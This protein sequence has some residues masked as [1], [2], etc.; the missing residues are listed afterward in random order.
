MSRIKSIGISKRV[1][2]V[3]FSL[4]VLFAGA[5]S[6]SDAPVLC[7]EADTPVIESGKP[8]KV[9]VR[10]MVRPPKVRDRGRVPL[11]VAIVLDKSGS[12][13]SDSKMENARL[14]ALEALERLDARDIASVVAY[15]S[16]ARVLVS[17]RPAGDLSGFRRAIMGVRAGGSTALFGGVELGA[18]K[19]RSLVSEGYIPRLIILS[20]GQAN[21][22]PS[23]TG[24]L[25]ALGR[26][27]SRD[28]MTITTIGLGLD[29][30]EDLMT[31]LA[32]E[33]GGNAYFAK[34]ASAL[35]GIFA[36]DMD[37]AVALTARRVR[38]TIECASSA[39]P[40]RVVGRSG[41]KSGN[42]LTASIDNL[43]GADKYALFEIEV[44]D[45]SDVSETAAATVKLEYIDAG[46]G[47]T[48]V[49]RSPLNLA[50][51]RDA[52]EAENSRNHE[53][54]AQTEL[55]RNA[56][57]REEVI[58]L[59]DEGRA[60]EAAKMLKDRKS[61]LNSLPAS[62]VMAAPS[63]SAEAEYFDELADDIEA[64]GRMSPEQRKR[65]KNEAYMEKNQQSKAD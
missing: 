48:V 60:R 14:G 37:D 11:A 34:D 33:S 29:Y 22:G 40:V 17:P 56:E 19:L 57:I 9:V 24:A 59:A 1:F 4:L 64:D 53:I 39:V 61:Y 15:D 3:M 26:R 27:L 8:A 2:A 63:I 13:G 49:D 28:E 58:R 35:G 42:T 20:D 44:P 52:R 62:A 31:A 32:S 45:V 6:A 18:D 36:R 38:V 55:A 10:A 47:K 5:A 25:A 12:M 51:T 21:V 7:V 46:T 30:N 43:Y 23:S 54:V 65:N 16:E 41:E 50:V